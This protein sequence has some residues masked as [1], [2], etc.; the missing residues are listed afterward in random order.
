MVPKLKILILNAMVQNKRN[1]KRVK[2][3][4]MRMVWKKDE[5]EEEKRRKGLKKSREEEEED[6]VV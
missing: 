3:R 5:T 4:G 2:A 1:I 6:N